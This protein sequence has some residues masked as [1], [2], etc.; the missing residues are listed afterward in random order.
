MLNYTPQFLK[1][2]SSSSNYIY[3]IVHIDI[4]SGL[5]ISNK[6]GLQ[7]NNEDLDGNYIDFLD[8]NLE[9]G[10]LN[11]EIDIQKSKFSTSQLSFSISNSKSVERRF[12]DLIN[13]LRFTGSK[14]KIYV[15]SETCQYLSDCINIYTGYITDIEANRYI[16]Q[17]TLEDYSTYTFTNKNIPRRKNQQATQELIDG[18]ENVPIPLVYGHVERS[19]MLM[20]RPHVN[21]LK[22]YIYPD[23]VDQNIKILGFTSSFD[24]LK[25]FR[26]K[27]YLDIPP[28]FQEVGSQDDPLIINGINYNLLYVGEPQYDI[29]DDYI[30][31]EKKV[32][33]NVFTQGMPLNIQA[34]EQFQVD[35]ERAPSGVQPT[36]S[37]SVLQYGFTGEKAIVFN[38]HQ[39]GYNIS[40]SVNNF[41]FPVPTQGIEMGYYENIVVG[42]ITRKR[43]DS[44]E[45]SGWIFYLNHCL[46]V[47]K[48]WSNG[49]YDTSS[50]GVCE[51]VR[52]PTAAEVAS[53]L[54][55]PEGYE[56][57]D[58]M[59][60]KI[61]HYRYVDLFGEEQVNQYPY[62]SW[63]QLPNI[64]PDMGTPQD[65]W[66]QGQV[67]AYDMNL[68]YQQH[69]DDSIY[70]HPAM[71]G[72]NI[73]TLNDS[74]Y[75]VDE[76]DMTYDY[77]YGYSFSNGNSWQD[78]DIHLDSDL[79][80]Y[81]EQGIVDYDAVKWIMETGD[82]V[83]DTVGAGASTNTR[84]PT[85]YGYYAD[86]HTPTLRKYLWGRRITEEEH[87][88]DGGAIPLGTWVY[89][90]LPIIGAFNLKA[91]TLQGSSS[92]VQDYDALGDGTFAYGNPY[93]Y[94]KRNS[95][96]LDYEE[97]DSTTETP[98]VKELNVISIVE[99]PNAPYDADYQWAIGLHSNF[100]YGFGALMR[101]VYEIGEGF[102]NFGTPVGA[103][104]VRKPFIKSA[105]NRARSGGS[106]CPIEYTQAESKAVKLD[107]TFNSVSGADILQ[108]S[109]YS[110]FK[111]KLTTDFGLLEVFDSS[112]TSDNNVDF[113][114]EADCFKVRAGD[115]SSNAGGSGHND[116]I[117]KKAV[118]QMPLSEFQPQQVI[119]VDG[120]VFEELLPVNPYKFST[121]HSTE[122]DEDT[123]YGTDES[124]GLHTYIDE[125]GDLVT[126]FTTIMNECDSHEVTAD[127]M[128]EG[129]VNAW[130]E[131]LNTIDGIS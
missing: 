109:V 45:D 26:D 14:T 8:L 18:S 53:F 21:D 120:N 32:S 96:T 2:L 68:L 115:E 88:V 40:D 80:P 11:E 89:G 78:I 72:L 42:N 13:T 130:R 90:C 16:C 113:L 123:H 125:S 75:N 4:D 10:S 34:R 37:D 129:L 51:I 66:Y 99:N 61:R 101:D 22:T 79:T 30:L 128:E 27:L 83:E 116:I 107:I 50:H 119:D 62:W 43:F 106:Y 95:E 19:K 114:I 15:A 59:R 7:L 126:D 23:A 56:P 25:I 57:V 52:R 76:K 49:Q 74:V 60:V 36:S 86:Y 81:I 131:N 46:M 63:Q 55:L 5:W 104:H 103:S 47:S 41:S 91:L 93:W 54:N 64:I 6:K 1:S 98:H 117:R 38:G 102:N 9:V 65:Y 58:E 31:V 71:K 110:M 67:Y 127:E 33:G 39:N 121:G 118:N 124:L 35:V 48:F 105:G 44:S 108:G 29:S 12:S 100:G 73:G 70:R 85:V 112:D 24:T 3:Y 28:V 17:I 122:G 84:K 94:G 87:T 69:G 77:V 92:G 111:C 97:W 20:T 82:G